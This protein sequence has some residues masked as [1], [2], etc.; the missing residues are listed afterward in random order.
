[1]RGCDGASYVHRQLII[2]P[3]LK[4]SNDIFYHPLRHMADIPNN[5][6]FRRFE[7]SLLAGSSHALRKV[8]RGQTKTGCRL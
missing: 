2:H 4:P 7:V 3:D 8:H 1:V 5:S 6:S